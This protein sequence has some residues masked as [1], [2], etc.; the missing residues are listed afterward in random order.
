MTYL[1]RAIL[2][3]EGLLQRHEDCEIG[4]CD[5]LPISVGTG[6]SRLAGNQDTSDTADIIQVYW[7]FSLVVKHRSAP[8][9]RELSKFDVLSWY[10]VQMPTLQGH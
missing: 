3:R 8:K 9:S 5:H 10:F 7:V 1:G 6:N 4:T 2:L